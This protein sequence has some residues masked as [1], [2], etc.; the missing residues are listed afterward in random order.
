[1]YDYEVRRGLIGYSIR[2][3][4]VAPGIEILNSL[5]IDGLIEFIPVSTDAIILAVE[6]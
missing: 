3:R 2:S 6:L 4:K 1:L 5:K